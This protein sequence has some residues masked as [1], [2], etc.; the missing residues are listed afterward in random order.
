MNKEPLVSVVMPVYNRQEY[1]ADA[2]ESILSQT[3]TD[4]E[5]IIVDDG[6][7]DH[8]LDII[9]SF[10]KKD[11]RIRVV[12]NNNNIGVAKTRNIGIELAKGKY[13]AFMD[14]DD[15]SHPDRFQRQVSYLENNP[16]IFVLGTSYAIINSTGEVI[17]THQTK[18]SPIEVRW[19][20]ISKSAIVNPSTM[21]RNEIFKVH[22]FQHLEMK[23]ASDYDLWNRV[24]DKFN[25]ENLPD[26]LI[27]FRDHKERLSNTLKDNQKTNAIKIIRNRVKHLTG[28]YLSDEQIRGLNNSRY[29]LK[30]RDAV[31]ISKTIICLQK[32]AMGWGNDMT[33]KKKIKKYA[34]NWLRSIWRNNN[35]SVRLAPFL[36]YSLYL[37]PQYLKYLNSKNR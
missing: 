1:V 14:S 18:L 21:S 17:S 3:F 36:L 31:I 29:I 23:A 30:I 16:E 10:V 28:I 24:C 32:T 11:N 4:F 22:G 5:F 37:D 12:K 8:S 25:I 33:D 15:V 27:Y 2:I 35:R 26:V 13:I 20:L 7:T 19:A 6:S 34:A 9:E